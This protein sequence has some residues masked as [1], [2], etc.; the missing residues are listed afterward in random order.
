MKLRNTKKLS[1][2]GFALLITLIVVTVVVSVTLAIVELSL[3]QLELSVDSVDSELAFQAAN[4]GLECARF[5]RKTYSDEFETGNDVTFDCFN[6]SNGAIP[7][8][9]SNGFIDNSKGEVYRYEDLI[10]W[11]S[12]TTVPPSERC[13]EMRVISM[14]V[15]ATSTGPLIIGGLGV[16]SLKTKLPGYPLD[17]ATCDVGGF[18]TIAS[19][20]GYS[21]NC[22][23]KNLPST[24]RREILLEF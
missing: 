4:A 24:R 16:D 13:S 21:S 14:V 18:C 3:K 1:S 19:V 2:P 22:A 23:D 8:A 12:P 7:Q 5:T 10:T 20:T 11:G 17:T 9:T 6:N 15:P